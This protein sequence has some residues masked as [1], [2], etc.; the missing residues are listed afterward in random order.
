MPGA[1][2]R[3]VAQPFKKS[4]IEVLS[5]GYRLLTAAEIVEKAVQREL[6]DPGQTAQAPERIM[7]AVLSGD[8]RRRGPDSQFVRRGERFG[9]DPEKRPSAGARGCAGRPTS[10]VPGQILFNGR[11][12]EH[13]VVGELLFYGFDARVAAVDEGT[14]VFAVKGGRRFLF[15]VKTSVP[16]RDKCS[17]FIPPGAHEKFSL[18]GAYYAFVMR[19]GACNDFLVMPHSEVQKHVESGRIV[20]MSRKYRA[21]FVWGE[22]ITL[23]GADVTRYRRRWPEA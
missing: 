14:D 13:S 8:M 4:A 2:G 10:H 11:A 3:A 18:P 5:D 7:K 6:L 15:Q 22:R 21:S 17:F 16:V 1:R 12:G 20:R 19:S 23:G 9:L